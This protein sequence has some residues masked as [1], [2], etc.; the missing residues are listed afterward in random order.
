[1]QERIKQLQAEAES[2]EANKLKLENEYEF[3]KKQ[4]KA[5]DKK[6]KAVRELIDSIK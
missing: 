2:Y 6:I 3:I 5:E 4:I 1:M